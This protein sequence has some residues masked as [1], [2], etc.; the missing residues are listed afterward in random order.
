MYPTKK[1]W[2][3]GD[4]GTTSAGEHRKHMACRRPWRPHGVAPAG[5]K[6]SC[7]IACEAIE[8]LPR[9]SAACATGRFCGD[10]RGHTITGLATCRTR[11]H[12]TT[13]WQ[14]VSAPRGATGGTR[15]FRAVFRA[16]TGGVCIAPC[17]HR[18]VD[19]GEGTPYIAFYRRACGDAPPHTIR[20][21]RVTH[22]FPRKE[23]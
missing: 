14:Y 15:P 4:R 9:A 1:P 22:A 16:R 7:P 12:N 6:P 5:Q 17:G 21:T 18:P 8:G 10:L 20:R 13:R 2:R 3:R 23:Q 11:L 19:S